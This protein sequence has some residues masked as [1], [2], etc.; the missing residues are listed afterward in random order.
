VSLLRE[1]GYTA[2]DHFE[3][4]IYEWQEAG[5]P[6]ERGDE[7]RATV[8]A[9]VATTTTTTTSAPITVRAGGR[10]R[11]HALVDLFERRSTADLVTLWFATILA[12]AFAYWIISATGLGGL[13]EGDRA[14]RGDGQGFLTSLYFSF[15]TATSVGFGDVVPRGILRGIAIVEAVFGLLVF[16]AVVSKLVSRRQEQVIEEIHRIAFEDRLERVQADLHLVLTE[17][18]EISRQ[19]RSRD[20]DQ[21][22]VRTRLE[23]AAGLCLSE[24]K[25]IHDLLYRPQSLPEERMLEGILAT[26]AMVLQELRELL[27]C[28]SFDKTAYLT[29]N[30]R[31]VADL[32]DDICS[33]CVPRSYAAHLREWMD[34]VKQTAPDLR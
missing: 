5:L 24:L 31:G 27:R 23:S 19:C 26:L 33:S 8:P 30:L 14:L 2:V 32:A 34:A 1:L 15:V 3:G 11:G 22:Q 7:S 25:T 20:S 6:L 28:I 16:G 4:G 12:C 18:Q 21:N 9:P 29:K 17:L 10:E 13:R